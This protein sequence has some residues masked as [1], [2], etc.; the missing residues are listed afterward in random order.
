MFEGFIYSLHDWRLHIV[1]VDLDL[2]GFCVTNNTDV[3]PLRVP[4]GT[5]RGLSGNLYT[6]SV[7]HDEDLIRVIIRFL[8]KVNVIKV[9]RVLITKE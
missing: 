8:A 1:K 2:P 4:V 3:V 6:W 7:F 5:I 9:G